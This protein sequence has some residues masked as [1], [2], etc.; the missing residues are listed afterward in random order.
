MS[1]ILPPVPPVTI[2]A[3]PELFLFNR[4]TKS[5]VSAHDL[6][7][8]TKY[9]PYVTAKGA[10]QVDGVS[11]EFNIN[12]AAEVEE[13]INNISHTTSLM[14]RM[15][16]D[17]ELS[18]VAEPVAYFDREYFDSLP[19]EAK[20][21]GCSPDYNAWTGKVNPSPKTDEP[22]RTGS[23]HIH[24]GFTEDV[25]PYNPSHFHDCCEIVKQLD[26]IL[27]IPSHIWDMDAKRRS[28]YGQR[29]AFRPKTYGCEYRVLSN[30][31]VADPDIAE[32]I[33]NATT[34]A[35]TLLSLGQKVYE[36][37]LFRE[38]SQKENIT[39]TDVFQ[40]MHVLDK[41]SIPS[42]PKEYYVQ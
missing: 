15:I 18:L 39:P 11:A 42:L 16:S 13:F 10:I 26:A 35:H 17:P 24:I 21:L 27:Y 4:R 3:D 25:D 41:F 1:Q 33:F 14:R 12:P 37:P 38:I 34:E 22:F 19:D 6:F 9:D 30:K 8:G 5:Y 36:Q 2:G 23:G 28:L 29:G 20:A 31:W 40:Y 32:W 7:P